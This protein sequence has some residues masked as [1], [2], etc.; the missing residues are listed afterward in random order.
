MGYC[1]A[2]GGNY[3][4]VVVWGVMVIFIGCLASGG[5]LLRAIV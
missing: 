5:N 2:S 1:V 4:C 3:F